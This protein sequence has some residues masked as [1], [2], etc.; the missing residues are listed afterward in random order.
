MAIYLVGSYLTV[1]NPDLDPEK[2]MLAIWSLLLGAFQFSSVV[3]Q[4]PDI[5]RGKAAGAKVFDLIEA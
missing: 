4:G 1:Y 2:V 3:A 5:K